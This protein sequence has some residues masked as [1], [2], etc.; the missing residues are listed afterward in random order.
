MLA[1]MLQ[2]EFNKADKPNNKPKEEA[3]PEVISP[4]PELK[5]SEQS[6]IELQKVAYL[7]K[8]NTAPYNKDFKDNLQNLMSMGFLDFT[9][10]L[11]L[12]A[13]HHNNLEPVLGKLIDN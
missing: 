8:L 5:Q 13:Q 11:A 9:K 4:D 6:A 1:A 2:S 12:L 7:E 10:N 3:K